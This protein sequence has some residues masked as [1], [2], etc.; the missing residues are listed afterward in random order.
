MVFIEISVKQENVCKVSLVITYERRRFCSS[1]YADSSVKTSFRKD[2]FKLLKHN[3]EQK[4]P[5]SH[6]NTSVQNHFAF[7]H[8]WTWLN[9]YLSAMS[10]VFV[11]TNSFFYHIF[12]VDQMQNVRLILYNDFHFYYRRNRHY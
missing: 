1:F 11:Q 8:L 7:A 5:F 10:I 3:V 4:R 6:T 9:I 2:F 12:N